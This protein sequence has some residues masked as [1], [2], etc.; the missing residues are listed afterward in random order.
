[1]TV[2]IIEPLE[3]RDQLGDCV[4]FR[5]AGFSFEVSGTPESVS[6]SRSVMGHYLP[7][8]IGTATGDA[9]RSIELSILPQELLDR[10]RSELMGSG[11]VQ[12]HNVYKSERLFSA[13]SEGRLVYFSCPP[14]DSRLYWR[15][16][17]HLHILSAAKGAG[18]EVLR[19]SREVATRMHESRGG[20]SVH[21]ASVALAGQGILLAGPSGSGKTTL[22]LQLLKHARAQ[23][24][25]N[26][27]A[28]VRMEEGC[29]VVYASPLP[30]RLS[31][32]TVNSEPGVIRLLQAGNTER[33][34]LQEY[35][36]LVGKQVVLNPDGTEAK[37]DLSP[38]EVCDLYGACAIG[39]S[40][41]RLMI[42]PTFD[43]SADSTSLSEL[44]EDE[45]R[46]V[47]AGELRTP[48]DNMWPEPWIEP[49]TDVNRSW[50][51][52]LDAIPAYRLRFGPTSGAGVAQAVSDLL[53]T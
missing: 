45:A 43:S 52:R 8:S 20:V 12:V 15:G 39:E 53:Q 17:T 27:R 36:S 22:L 29:A 37:A 49:G 44:S 42:V 28:L 33:R 10:A 46:E 5:I 4:A 32:G 40:P 9:D 41:L 16:Q 3:R 24:L 18:R 25:C 19:L 34:Q 35:E 6:Q 2:K 7:G 14:S 21:A 23:F 48:I 38:L 13:M 30:V 26:D 51:Y 50:M 47:L 31:A 11:K 1:L